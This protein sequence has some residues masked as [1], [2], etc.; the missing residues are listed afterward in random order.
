MTQVQCF[1]GE[2]R[3]NKVCTATGDIIRFLPLCEHGPIE[4][5]PPLKV[6]STPKT[7][8]TCAHYERA[9]D[10]CYRYP[11]TVVFGVFDAAKHGDYIHITRERPEVHFDTRACG[12]YKEARHE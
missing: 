5:A 6:T 7:C 10:R 12:E 2:T 8:G 1:C 9:N 3:G 4:Y 11:P